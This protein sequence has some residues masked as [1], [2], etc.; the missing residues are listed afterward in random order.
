[1]V[2][3]KFNRIVL[4][5]ALLILT[6]NCFAQHA[7]SGQKDSEMTLQ[8]IEL[9]DTVLTSGLSKLFDLDLGYYSFDYYLMDLMPSSITS[10]DYCFT[11]RRM[12][13][14]S[15]EEQDSIGFFTV[16][17]RRCI[18]I[19]R[20]IPESMCSLLSRKMPVPGKDDLKYGLS[21]S[22]SFYLLQKTG[23]ELTLLIKEPAD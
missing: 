23:T 6:V 17:G 21:G 1:M 16:I 3:N 7:A 13:V 10:G 2:L 19:S 20:N 12:P 22:G 15:Q 8:E 5:L 14:L 11:L 4:S 18:I 9:K